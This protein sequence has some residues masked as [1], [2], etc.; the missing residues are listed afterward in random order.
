MRGGGHARATRVWL[1]RVGPGER[2]GGFTLIEIMVCVMIVATAITALQLTASDALKSAVETN[3]IR[4]AKMLLLKKAEEVVAG[5]EEGQSGSFEGYPG[6]QWEVADQELTLEE[7]E[8]SVRSVTITVRY[9]TLARSSQDVEL[10]SAFDDVLDGPG[11][12]SVTILLDPE[13]AELKPG[14]R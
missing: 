12:T 2:E 1:R 10:D 13:D 3:R 14:P 8:E 6:Y 11:R 7:V 4:A 5:V 9:P